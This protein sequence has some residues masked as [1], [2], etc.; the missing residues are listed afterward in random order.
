ME[1]NDR[2]EIDRAALAN[3]ILAQTEE[4]SQ[5]FSCQIDLARIFQSLEY[6]RRGLR[7]AVANGASRLLREIILGFPFSLLTLML[8]LE[9]PTPATFKQIP[10]TDL[11]NAYLPLLKY[12]VICFS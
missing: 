9:P 8:R 2:L 12:T 11:Y 5:L 1:L 6:S 10:E 3:T 4:R 7:L